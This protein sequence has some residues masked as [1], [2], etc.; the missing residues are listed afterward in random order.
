MNVIVCNVLRIYPR[1]TDEETALLS[2]EN[3][4]AGEEPDE[5]TLIEMRKLR[6]WITDVRRVPLSLIA[7]CRLAVR[8][9]LSVANGYR[10]IRPGISALSLP[11]SLRQYLIFEGPLSE[12]D[13][14]SH[15]ADFDEDSFD[16]KEDD[17]IYS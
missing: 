8:R 3:P 2:A 17:D 16:E 9:R 13:L 14:S 11:E 10:D 12:V 6:E 15:Y 5:S 1:N 4:E 7:H